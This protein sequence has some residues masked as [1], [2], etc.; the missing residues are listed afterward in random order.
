MQST[1]CICGYRS[2]CPGKDPHSLSVI[3]LR[4]SSYRNAVRASF[5][6]LTKGEDK[7][8]AVDHIIELWE[9]KRGAIR[10]SHQ[11]PS[12]LNCFT[13]TAYFRATSTKW[14][15]GLSEQKSHEMKDIWDYL[16]KLSDGKASYPETFADHVR[17]KLHIGTSRQ[18][19]IVYL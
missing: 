16:V 19:F 7:P 11:S 4:G 13:S 6:H 5:P 10:S 12:A 8:T 15:A 2:S 3:D 9:V 18:G 14:D 17:I 1:N